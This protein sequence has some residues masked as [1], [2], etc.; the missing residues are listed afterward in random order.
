MQEFGVYDG[1]LDHT[2]PRWFTPIGMLVH[3]H[4][5]GD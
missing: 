5:M 1:E 3:S 2:D 4:L